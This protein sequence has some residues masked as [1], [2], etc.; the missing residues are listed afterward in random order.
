MSALPSYPLKLALTIASSDSGGGAGIQADLKTFAALGVYG[1]TAI[2]AATAQNTVEVQALETLSPDMVRA[3]LEAVFSD[4]PVSAVKIGLLGDAANAR[5]TARFL[6]SLSPKVPIV[7]DPVMASAAGH[8]FLRPEAQEALAELFPL[9]DLITPNM[10]EAAALTGLKVQNP[11]D[12]APAARAL[13][14][15]GPRA[16]LLK[17]GHLAFTQELSDSLVIEDLYLA[18]DGETA[19]FR[20]PFI[21]TQADH[22]T[23]CSLSAAIAAFLAQGATLPEACRDAKA[24]VARAMRDG[25]PLGRGHGPLHHFHEFYSFR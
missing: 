21:K 17:G 11:E 18:Q 10:G 6:E 12:F 20:G 14:Q 8:V 2:A 9:V 25:L 22:G 13:L 15:K 4:F 16:V 3:Q 7:L 24:Y 5:V 19:V 23:G 1:L